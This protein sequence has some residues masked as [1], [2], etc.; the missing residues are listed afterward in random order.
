MAIEVLFLVSEFGISFLLAV[1]VLSNVFNQ[2]AHV[3][4]SLDD[5]GTHL[6]PLTRH[7][8]LLVLNVLILGRLKCFTKGAIVLTG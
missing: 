1:V 5:V 7:E 3:F 6:V 8:I 4:C 2:Q